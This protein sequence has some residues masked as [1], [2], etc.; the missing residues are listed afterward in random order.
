MPG[1]PSTISVNPPPRQTH[2]YTPPLFIDPSPLG[3]QTK[4]HFHALLKGLLCFRTNLQLSYVV[5]V[6]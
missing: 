6:R 2:V 4:I 3:A 1:A 5:V